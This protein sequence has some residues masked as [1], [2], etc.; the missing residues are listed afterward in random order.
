MID[1]VHRR[2]DKLPL[3]I[4]SLPRCVVCHARKGSLCL[5]RFETRS[6]RSSLLSEL[7]ES[8]ALV[9]PPFG[10]L[11]SLVFLLPSVRRTPPMG[12]GSFPSSFCCLFTLSLVTVLHS[13]SLDDNPRSEV[14]VATT[15]F[16]MAALVWCGTLTMIPCDFLWQRPSRR[17]TRDHCC[18]WCPSF[19]FLGQRHPLA[20]GHA[21]QRHQKWRSDGRVIW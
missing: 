9:A 7:V 8:T 6:G 20:Q 17:T 14:D 3:Q 15:T 10:T 12:G 1:L 18:F 16:Q 19:L 13:T 2:A 5:L 21:Q 11:S 4:S